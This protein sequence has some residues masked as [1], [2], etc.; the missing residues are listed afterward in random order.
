M[1][2]VASLV[3]EGSAALA[4]AGIEAP[5]AEARLLIE[6]ATGLSR[7]EQVRAAE[8]P[9]TEQGARAYRELVAR[10]AAREPMA[11]LRGRAEF[12]S[13]ELAVGPG[14]L[15][16]R[17]DSE[18]LV[19]AAIRALPERAAAWRCLDLGVGSG[20]LILALLHHFPNAHGVGTDASAAAL[21]CAAA[22]ARRLGLSA[23]LDLVRTSWADGVAGIFDLVVANPPYIPTAEI[24]SLQP[25]V[26]RFE[27]R[28]ALDGGGDGLDAYRA[29][30]AELPRL[31]AP[32]G[33][34][35]LEIGLGQEEALVSLAAAGGFSTTAHRD[36]AGI[37]RCLEL[38]SVSVA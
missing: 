20:C 33:I 3:A 9:V 12:W 37:I 2:A 38:H 28:A 18:T 13:L 31:L 29:I 19:G 23:R 34:C 15:V 30:L 7:T 6:I 27:P 5:R 4:A 16:P 25:E 35:L 36:L 8:T 22:N 1:T 26:A 14:V 32:Q 11:Y 24:A 17:A 10:R 21:A